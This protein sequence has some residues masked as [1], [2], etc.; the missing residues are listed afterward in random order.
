MIETK[1]N[2]HA[3]N[4]VDLLK[5]AIMEAFAAIDKDMVTKACD[6]SRVHFEMVVAAGGG[7]IEK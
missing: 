2:K 5:A 3:Y 1:T 6:S 7:Y 4:T